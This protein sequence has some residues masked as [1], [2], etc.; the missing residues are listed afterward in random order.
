MRFPTRL[1]GLRVLT[2]LGFLYGG[3][4]IG[5]E[6]SLPGVILLSLVVGLLALAHAAQRV[7]GGR[8]MGRRAWTG[9]AGLGGLAL[10]TGMPVLI[11]LFMV[12]KTGLHSHG[13]EFT[14]DELNWVLTQAP[15]WAAS[16]LLGGLGLGLL[17]YR[18]GGEH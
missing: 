6:G 14:P 16:G 4:W 8:V 10:G 9:V 17:L 13:P 3:V 1:P 15:W 12:L 5:L 7:L 18:P 11:L 2:L